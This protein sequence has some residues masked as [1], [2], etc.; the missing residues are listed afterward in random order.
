MAMFEVY[1]LSDAHV[2]EAF[3]QAAKDGCKFLLLVDQYICDEMLVTQMGVTAA[4][5]HE[6]EIVPALRSLWFGDRRDCPPR[7]RAVY[8]TEKRW[9]DQKDV[10]VYAETLQMNLSPRGRLA[11]APRSSLRVAHCCHSKDG[12][13]PTSA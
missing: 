11:R 6:A 3:N 1:P 8:D 5:R 2:K 10:R 4:V 7:L 9:R 13:H 12:A